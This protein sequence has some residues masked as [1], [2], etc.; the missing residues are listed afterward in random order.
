MAW[1]PFPATLDSGYYVVELPL[2][3]ATVLY[4]GDW[5]TPL[6]DELYANGTG[7]YANR[8]PMKIEWDFKPKLVPTESVL[9]SKAEIG[10]VEILSNGVVVDT[11]DR[12]GAGDELKFTKNISNK[13]DWNSAAFKADPETERASGWKTLN[14]K[15][16]TEPIA[17]QDVDDGLSADYLG[18]VKVYIR[19]AWFDANK[20]DDKAPFNFTVRFTDGSGRVVEQTCEVIVEVLPPE[21]LC[22]YWS[23]NPGEAVPTVTVYADLNEDF[24]GQWD[25]GGA[26]TVTWW[27]GTTTV[28]N[29]TSM[30]LGLV[31]IGSKTR[32]YTPPTN[33][34]PEET[35]TVALYGGVPLTNR[36]SQGTV[37][38]QQ[39]AGGPFLFGNSEGCC[40]YFPYN[41]VYEV[42][43]GECIFT[44][45][46]GCP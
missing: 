1:D 11:R 8:Y 2:L 10:K 27:D 41:T 21:P 25:T 22:W 42:C 31:T 14:N 36:S 28:K 29:V 30:D 34:P 18:S 4:Y 15:L 12:D 40:E 33:P 20:V 6:S 24:P 26:F 39:D 17:R 5:N 37:Q 19:K 45:G 16:L 44:G 32:A 7:G 35:V 38:L 9:G 3:N 46:G 23:S 43:A 13:Y